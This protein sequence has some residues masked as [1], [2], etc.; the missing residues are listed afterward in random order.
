MAEQKIRETDADVDAFLAGIPDERKRADA[1][2]VLQLMAEVTGEPP[3]MWGSSMVGFGRYHYRYD[4]GREGDSFLTGFS[5]RSKALSL[6]IMAGFDRYDDLMA[7]L[8]TY[9]TGKS[10]L[11]VTRLSNIDLD[12]LR[13]LVQRSVAHM[14]ET[15]PTSDP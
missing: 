5:P 9:K 12:V 6:Y 1:Q 3:R 11:Y 4:S 2:A 8:G 13:E 7:Q 14:R 15:W 10:C